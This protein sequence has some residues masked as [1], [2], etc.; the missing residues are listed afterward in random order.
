MQHEIPRPPN[1]TLELRLFVFRVLQ[2]GHTVNSELQPDASTTKR[3]LEAWT[4]LL[5]A[6]SSVTVPHPS[7]KEIRKK[8]VT[9]SVQG[10]AGAARSAR[11]A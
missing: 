5:I 3:T 7:A 4:Q 6:A 1:L 9:R 11:G 2:N 10:D 8:G